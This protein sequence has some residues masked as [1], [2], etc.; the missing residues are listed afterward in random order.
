MLLRSCTSGHAP[1]AQ[2][3]EHLTTDQEVRGS[4]P[5]GCTHVD[6]PRHGWGP[7]GHGGWQL[8][9]S[10]LHVELPVSPRRGEGGRQMVGALLVD[11]SRGMRLVMRRLIEAELGWE[12][13]A[14][15]GDGAQALDAVRLTCPDVIVLDQQM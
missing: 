9:G 4:N 5:F 13:V 3:I 11:D 6:R 2:R 14:E 15:A 7:V 1:V 12:V 10:S 8:G